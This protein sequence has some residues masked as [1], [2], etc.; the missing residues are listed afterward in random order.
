MCVCVCVCVYAQVGDRTLEILELPVRKWTQ[1][2]KEFLEGLVRPE[3]KDAVRAR[4]D[5]H[6]MLAHPSTRSQHTRGAAC[7]EYSLLCVAP[8]TLRWSSHGD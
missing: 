7:V 3:E 4:A 6:R 8:F 1:D 2:Y 5:A